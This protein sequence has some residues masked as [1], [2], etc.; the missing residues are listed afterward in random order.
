MHNLLFIIL[1]SFS[2]TNSFNTSWGKC[3]LH[4][5]DSYVNSQELINIINSTI[6]N[7]NNKY[8]NVKKKDF[9]IYIT[10]TKKDYNT[11]S[12]GVAPSWSVGI[13]KSDQII[14]KSPSLS[15]M[16]E[17]QFY[18]VVV[19]ELNH[20]YVNRLY[21]NHTIPKWFKEGF[22]GL[23]ANQFSLKHKINISKNF[24]S[25]SLLSINDLHSFKSINSSNHRLAYSQS[26]A[27]VDGLKYYYG[28]E[29]I[30]KIIIEL[31]NGKT[32]NQSIYNVTKQKVDIVINQLFD[33]KKSSYKWVFILDL[34]NIIFSIL[35]FVLIFGFL[36]KKYNN[37]K[38]IKKWEEEELIEL[39]VVE[40]EE[41]LSI[42]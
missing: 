26:Y 7:M 23:I 42:S 12:N 15:K 35:P 39:N 41:D 40:D 34:K 19:H 24:W 11:I 25:N 10:N 6:S 4:L 5:T 3:Y 20:L 32:F 18:K 1:L 8:G 14:I 21:N 30:E 28:N 38:I 17:S 36:F 27:L 29:V 37:S 13:T 31:R 22:A 9:N 16:S 33:Y 2:L